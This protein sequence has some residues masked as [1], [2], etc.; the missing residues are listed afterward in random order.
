MLWPGRLEQ[1]QAKVTTMESNS[2]E[3]KEKMRLYY[4]ENKHL[5]NTAKHKEKSRL[6]RIANSQKRLEQGRKRRQ[7]ARELIYMV[8]S[9]PCTDCGIEYPPFVM[10][11]DHV[12]GLKFKDVSSMVD[13]TMSQKSIMAEVAKCEVVCSNCHRIRTHTR[14]KV[15]GAVQIARKATPIIIRKVIW[16]K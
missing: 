4:R 2:E 16:Q 6:Y 3:R 15:G 11:L 5:W 13:N 9:V 14:R 7:L 8:K 12:R 1:H 10:D